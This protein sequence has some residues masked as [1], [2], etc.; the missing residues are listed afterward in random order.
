MNP[1]N[2]S[3]A[4]KK[5]L[6]LFTMIVFYMQKDSSLYAESTSIAVFFLLFF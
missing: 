2:A 3:F 6:R 1:R 4:K 5:V